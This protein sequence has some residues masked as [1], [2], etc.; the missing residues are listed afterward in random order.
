MTQ[1]DETTQAE[2][3][4][5]DFG[6]HGDGALAA[7][8]EWVA[9][10]R[11]EAAAKRKEKQARERLDAIL[12]DATEIFLAG[13]QILQY[14]NDGAFNE[15]RFVNEM[16]HIAS[17]YIRWEATKVFDREAFEADNPTLY[18]AYRSRTLRP[19]KGDE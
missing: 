17:L 14:D 5:F 9:A 6:D 12:G 2:A 7:Y 19:L 13:K 8:Q 4:K 18:T 1:T 11:N 15:T 10:K 3:K 16:P